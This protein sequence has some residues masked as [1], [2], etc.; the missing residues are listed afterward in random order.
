MNKEYALAN[1]LAGEDICALRKML[2][3]SR[4]EFA[5]LAGV[6]H[7]TVEFWEK[8]DKPITGPIVF[9]YHVL[10]ENRLIAQRLEIPEQVW[11]LRLVYMYKSIP[12]TVIDV[13][14]VNRLVK[15]YNY[16]DRHQFRAFGV[17]ENPDY[18]DLEYFL[19]SRCFPKSRDKIKLELE[20]LGL[21]FYDPLMIIEKTE[22]RMAE[23]LF[24]I[25]IIRR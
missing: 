12:C 13:D 24:H 22:G 20:R 9:M 8:S 23:D 11:P 3:I 14:E 15:A 10:F 17:I 18:N 1:A 6:S 16:T 19:E 2:G 21:P 7:R 25:Q 4:R 5:A